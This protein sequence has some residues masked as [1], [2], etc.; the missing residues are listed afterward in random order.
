MELGLIEIPVP[1]SSKFESSGHEN[2][3]TNSARLARTHSDRDDGNCNRRCSAL[4]T[5][6]ARSFGESSL[7]CAT[8]RGG[9]PGES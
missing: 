2:C 4:W 1:L 9:L 5:E 3:G 7:A 8:Q 6:F